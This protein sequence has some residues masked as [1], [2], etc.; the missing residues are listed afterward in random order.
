MVLGSRVIG[1]SRVSSDRGRP[2]FERA[3]TVVFAIS[4]G[5]SVLLLKLQNPLDLNLSEYH[6]SDSVPGS[7]EAVGSNI[8]KMR[9]GLNLMHAAIQTSCDYQVS[10]R[11]WYRGPL[12]FYPPVT[13]HL[14]WVESV[15]DIPSTPKLLLR[16][17]I[18]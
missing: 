13:T 11:G 14:Y 18:R 15:C 6:V 1:Q 8:L 2:S 9:S 10:N 5:F 16:E 17:S 3:W 7:S 4:L 12:A